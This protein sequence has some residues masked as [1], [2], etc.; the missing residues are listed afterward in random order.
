M[1][2]LGRLLRVQ[3]FGESHGPGL[4]V[5]LDGCPAGLALD[6]SDLEEDLA[7][8]RA[9]A[10]G[11]TPRMEADLPIFQSG[12]YQGHTTGRP[13]SIWFANA[14]VKSKDYRSLQSTWRPGHA[15]FTGHVKYHGFEDPRGG[16]A[17]S[18]RLTVGLVAA[19][20]IAKKLLAPARIDAELESVQGTEKISHAVDEALAEG[21]SVGGLIRCTSTGLAAGLGEPFFDSIESRL[22]HALFAIPG[23]KGVEFGTGFDCA[24]LHGS[25]YNDTILDAQGTTETNHCGGI[26]GGITNGNPLVFRVAVRP[27]ASIGKTQRTFSHRMNEM[28]ELSIQGRHDACIA[29]RVPVIVEAVTALVLADFHLIRQSQQARTFNS[30]RDES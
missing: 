12:V 14:N 29:L 15:D 9:G 25:D 4:G 22:S 13:I 6:P 3:L 11:T 19:G 30:E 27:T 24:T 16:G 28:T 26:N 1:N 17:F 23:I 7:R 5:V 2:Q 20:A 8:R 10:R 21:D 18:G